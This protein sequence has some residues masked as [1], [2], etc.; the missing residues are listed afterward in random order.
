MEKRLVIWQKK[1]Q[2]AFDAQMLWYY[3]NTNKQFAATYFKNIT[4]TVKHIQRCHLSDGWKKK[5]GSG[6]TVHSHRILNV[7]YYIGITTRNCILLIYYSRHV[8]VSVFLSSSFQR[9]PSNKQNMT[10]KDFAACHLSIPTPTM[11]IVRR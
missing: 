5:K 8:I 4:A 3:L 6:F 7:V 2:K 1:A 9:V 11:T 10:Q